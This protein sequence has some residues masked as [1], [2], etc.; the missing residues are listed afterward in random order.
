MKQMDQAM[1]VIPGAPYQ[2]CC[3]C[4]AV[5]AAYEED[6]PLARIVPESRDAAP[7]LNP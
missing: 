7:S 2:N 5:D 6:S 4:C 1:S 3:V